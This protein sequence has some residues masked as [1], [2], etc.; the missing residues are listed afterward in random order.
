M[1]EKT[2]ERTAQKTSVQTPRLAILATHPVQY[3]APWFRLL[4]KRGQINVKVFYTWGRGGIEKKY[5]PAFCQEI[6]WDIPLMEGYP[7]E[8]LKNTAKRPGSHHFRGI[9]NPTLISQIE[10]YRPDA[11]LVIGWAFQSHL[12]CMRY[13]K[14]RVPIFFRGD[15]TLLDE[16]NGWRTVVRR[17]VLQ[18]IYRLVDKA[19]YVGTQN[20]AYFEAHGLKKSQLISAPHAVDNER[21]G[22]A[23]GRNKEIAEFRKHCGISSSSFVLLFAGKLEPKK[24]PFFLLDL[25]KKLKDPSFA[26]LIIGNG[27]LEIELREAAKEDGRIKFLPFQNQSVMPVVY[28]SS[29]VLVFPS[30][31]PGETWGLAVNEAMACGLPV[32]VSARA[33]GAVDLVKE[34][35]IIFEEGAVDKVA[36][37][38]QTLTNASAYQSA[39]EASFCHIQNFSFQQLALAVEQTV[40]HTIQ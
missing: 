17:L 22:A 35:G 13:F 37:F 33:G 15:S 36:A 39:R 31:G 9:R 8:F 14:G 40:I 23:V 32:A 26:F 5:D 20:K 29:N 28:A 4:A 30:K 2:E 27:I 3:N 6:D 34:N 12:S 25:A 21:F 7:Y 38:V 18:R 24:N 16:Q 11:L 19:F 1:K 10:N